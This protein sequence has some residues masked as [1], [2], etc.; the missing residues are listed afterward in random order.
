MP[1][2]GFE[3][4]TSRLQ[5]A[6]STAELNGRGIGKG[7]ACD[8]YAAG[9]GGGNRTPISGF[10]DRCFTTKLHPHGASSRDRTYDARFFKPAL[11]Q[12]SYR[13]IWRTE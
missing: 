5:I 12:L 10:G 13:G 2:Q 1:A 4:W 6:C 3:P 11:Y 9:I 8:L 7:L